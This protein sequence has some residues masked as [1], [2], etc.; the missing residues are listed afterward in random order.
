MSAIFSILSFLLPG[1][2]FYLISSWLWRSKVDSGRCG[3]R[4]GLNEHGIG[5]ALAGGDVVDLKGEHAAGIRMVAQNADTCHLVL[6]SGQ[7]QET[8]GIEEGGAQVGKGG[9]GGGI[10]G[11]F[12]QL[13]GVLAWIVGVNHLLRLDEEPGGAVVLDGGAAA[14]VA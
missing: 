4:S 7:F 8:G 9:E 1:E 13:V 11:V 14:H 10:Q 12:Q 3:L 2:D 5:D 6:L